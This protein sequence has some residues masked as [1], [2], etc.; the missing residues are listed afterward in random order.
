V[1][2]ATIPPSKNQ[3][4]MEQIFFKTPQAFQNACFEH[5]VKP[6]SIITGSGITTGANVF[7]D[8]QIAIQ[9]ILDETEFNNC[10]TFQRGEK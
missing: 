7:I 2:W 8:G 10:S 1:G 3:N 6:S 9:L 4:I 5:D